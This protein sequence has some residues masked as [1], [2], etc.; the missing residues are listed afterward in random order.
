M[1]FGRYNLLQRFVIGTLLIVIP[2]ALCG[3]AIEQPGPESVVVVANSAVDGSLRVARA[4]MQRRAIP[5]NNLVVLETS[6]DE[7]ITR[8]VY[9][10]TIH[11]PLLQALVRQKLVDALAGRPDAFGRETVTLIANPLRYLVLCYGMPL[12]ITDLPVEELDDRELREAFFRG[13]DAAVHEALTEGPLARN[14]ASVDGELAM[15]LRRDIPFQGVVPNPF[16]NN[17]GPSAARDLLKV[18]RLD[19]P[20]PQDVIAMLDNA[21]RGEREGLKGR[22]Y[23]DEDGRGG[24]YQIGNDWLRATADIFRKL[25]FDLSHDTARQTF[26][27]DARMDAPALYAGWYA[28]HVNGPFALPSFRF[29]PGAVAAH[30]HSFSATTVRSTSRGWVGP[31][32]HRGVSATF[33]NVAEPY[34]RF[35]H[36][37]DQFFAALAGGANF[38]DAAY[39]ALPVLSWQAV[40]VGDPLFRPFAVSFEEQRKRVGDPRRILSDQYVFLRHIQLL[41][42]EE[43]LDEAL[44]QARRGMLDSPGPALGLERARL[45]EAAGQPKEALQ[46]LAFLAALEPGDANDW[47]LF[48]EIADTI[49]RLGDPRAALRL[50]VTLEQQ[51]MPD[52]ALVAFLKRGIPV[53]RQAGNIALAVDWEA[54][55]TPPAPPPP[56]TPAEPPPAPPAEAAPPAGPAQ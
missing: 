33:G 54:R 16:Y 32:V 45:L 9:R 6:P 19:G 39:F 40:A 21:L 43:R 42:A 11:N 12:R 30:L 28:A 51:P 17:P 47:G 31:F 14:G 48:A 38:A 8:A 25:G 44:R 3:Q 49:A 20:A 23:V 26:A 15:L 22:A 34:L 5:E 36:Q 52:N 29:P 46:A 56:R 37:F 10:D 35:T 13:A 18:T 27:V 24:G 41:K 55:V 4:Y 53:A 50:Y 2:L 1:D 7:T